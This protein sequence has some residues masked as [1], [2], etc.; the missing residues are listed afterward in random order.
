MDFSRMKQKSKGVNTAEVLAK[1][2]Q[3]AKSGG[4]EKDP[5]YFV[6][7]VDKDGNGSVTIR[8]LPHAAVDGEEYPDYVTLYKH[9]F[10]D[11]STQ[12]WYIE[13]SRTT[14]PDPNSKYGM[15]DPVSEANRALF[16]EMDKDAAIQFLRDK[17]RN[18][19]TKYIA[20]ILVIKNELQ[21]ETVGGN[22]LFEFGQKIMDKILAKTKA[23]DEDNPAFDAFN[24]F[25]GANFY[26]E[27]KVKDKQ[28]NY[29]DSE[30]AHP[31]PLFGGDDKKLEELYNKLYSLSAEIAPD[32]FKSYE[33][34]EKRFLMV[35]TGK[36]ASKAE[37][38]A[39]VPKDIPKEAVKAPEQSAPKAAAPAKSDYFTEDDLDIPF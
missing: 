39:P 33:E 34:L 12:Q 19:Q 3:E 24:L 20:N 8:F 6:P 2:A 25:E 27:M 29:D 18:R 31:K 10:K 13:N 14:L 32:K 4:F 36:A 15:P 11:E 35:T 1:R 22:Y 5:R 7:A 16:A 26:L 38:D 28:R 17:K 37:N 9:A 23:K 30:F 21:P